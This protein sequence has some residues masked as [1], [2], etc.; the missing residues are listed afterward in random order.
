M[1]LG[2]MIDALGLDGHAPGKDELVSGAIVMLQLHTEEHGTVLRV[3]SSAGLDW[4]TRRGMIE[5]AREDMRKG[6]S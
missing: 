4:V 3:L 6:M 1:S 2:Q 5:I